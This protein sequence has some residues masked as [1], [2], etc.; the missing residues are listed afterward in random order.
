MKLQGW[1]FAGVL[2]AT[3]TIDIGVSMAATRPGGG[4]SYSGSSRSSS[5]SS[6]SRS[7]S[8]SRR[9]SSSGYSS[10]SSYSGGSGDDSGV[11]FFITFGLLAVVAIG[12]AILE[13]SV[14]TWDSS[15]NF[16]SYDPVEFP[17]QPR[18]QAGDPF[19]ILRSRD[20][21]FS[22]ILLEDFLFELY[23]RAI[24]ARGNT[25]A[26]ARLQP[27]LSPK[28]REGLLGRG[29][30]ENFTVEGVVVGSLHTTK[31][32]SGSG[33]DYILVTFESNH[34]EVYQGAPGS[35]AKDLRL[36]YYTKESWTLVR[37][38]GVK[39]RQPEAA[40]ALNCPSC[41]APIEDSSHDKC[42]YCGVVHGSADFDWFVQKIVVTNEET[43]GPTLTGYAEEVGTHDYTRFDD[44]RAKGLKDLKTRD[45]D[46]SIEALRG[47]VH[48]IY[49]QLN[50]A[51]TSQAWEDARPYLS[52]RLWY[53]LRYWIDAYRAQ[54]LQNVMLSA[55]SGKVELVKLTTDAHY[56]SVTVR[57]FAEAIDQTIHLG[58]G[59]VVG[60]SERPREYS[61]YWTLIRSIKRK[62]KPPAAKQCPNCAAPTA[63]NM[64]GNCEHCGVKITGGEF[65]WVLSKIEQDESYTG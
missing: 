62:G 41:G 56:D 34:T 51:W 40:R 29:G 7:S 42:G 6:S 3:F 43:R 55:K 22:L 8:S 24:Q 19:T 50:S 38:Q 57:M 49:E 15:E 11:S 25:E 12:K 44:N 35:D 9:S 58:S 21:D 31:K 59:Q 46:F 18:R 36:G 61:E 16:Q 27:Y 5:R 60:G 4:H 48:L 13:K 47:R 20:P 45:P 52:D 30:R 65:D 64:A 54:G 1:V 28:V 17:S 33:Y 39:S 32:N 10:G 14:P 26:M 23:T 53:S 63:V 2:T 37:K